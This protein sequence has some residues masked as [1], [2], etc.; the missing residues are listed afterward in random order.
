MTAEQQ[1]E[2]QHLPL[3]LGD[4]ARPFWEAA[5]QRMAGW[6]QAR[7]VQSRDAVVLLP[8]AQHLASA[9]RA[10]RSTGLWQP[11]METT[12]SLASALGPSPLSQGLQISF[13][14][15]I[16]VLNARQLLAGQSWA[17]DLRRQ[18]AR[19]W[20]LALQHLVEAAQALARHAHA[21]GP[22]GRQAFWPRAR[23]ALQQSGPADLE[24]ALALVALEW[25]ASDSRVPATDAL[26]S[27]RPSAWVL[28]RAGGVDPLSDALLSAAA[29]DG[30]PCLLLDADRTLEQLA[31]DLPPVRLQEARCEDPESLAQCTAATVLEHIR[32][33]ELPVALIAQDR[34]LVRRVRALLERQ[35]VRLGDETG[36]TLATTPEAAQLMALLRAAQPRASIDELL[37]WLKSD[38]SRG[39]RERQAAD[40]VDQLESQ[41]RRLGWVQSGTV[42]ATH[43]KGPASRLW[44]D[45]QELL[46]ILRA[47]PA[48]RNL[49]QWL[50]QLR[51]LLERLG[52]LAWLGEQAAGRQ[53]LLA[54]WLQREPWPDSAHQLALQS[55]LL[56]STDFVQWVNETLEAQQFV[57]ELPADLQVL[58]TPMARAMLRPFAAIVLPGAD[59]LTLGQVAAGPV[60]LPDTLARQ[61]GMPDQ[62][63]RRAQL[64]AG[65]VQLLRAPHLTVL[66]CDR[67]GSEPLARSPL[68]ERLEAAREQSGA[69]AIPAWQDP[70]PRRALAAQPMHRAQASAAGQLPRA[71]SASALEALRNCPYQFFGLQLLGLR[72]DEELV[73]ELDKRDYGNWL[74][75]VL[76]RFHELAREQRPDDAAQALADAAEHERQRMG[77]SEA[78]FLPY[79]ASF[80][81]LQP[82]YLAW[83]AGHEA[84]G[85]QYEGGEQPRQCQPWTH[86]VLRELRLQGRLDRF[87]EQLGRRLLLDY[88]TGSTEAI[89]DRL[90]RPLEDTQLAVYALLSAE[91][92]AASGATLEAAYL[93]LDDSKGLQLLPHPQVALNAELL[94]QGLEQDLAEV[95]AGAALPALGE[96][97]ACALCPVRGL[98]RKDD[99]WEG[100]P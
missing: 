25:A 4:G 81:R 50:D 71:L 90:K 6:M 94:R 12:H 49:A 37:Q 5:V 89:K 21:L 46:A 61:L 91:E 42:Q 11:R 70:R 78:E 8:F 60:L 93:M 72:E 96:G 2:T 31:S 39:L 40:A 10:W 56:G 54:L 17:E 67:A 3:G 27:L 73:E 62:A 68:L 15:A 88:K 63:G 100:S 64:A 41:C 84:A 16:D 45:A 95:Q 69:G 36:W 35:S 58:V 51:R 80:R 33:Q 85:W 77:L 75:A 52:A 99:W 97:R 65:F 30:I 55:T 57:P 20:Q 9:R 13:D 23:Q 47:G 43:L 14:A 48:Q 24:Q 79:L 83:L 26:F 19:A 18:D 82:R 22:Q 92:A 34:V 44:Q 74:H 86:P 7:G 38:L 98:C 28:M 59:A 29:A 87:D 66:R 1:I 76:H 32:R 53:L